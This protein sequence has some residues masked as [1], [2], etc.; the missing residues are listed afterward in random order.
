MFFQ[1]GVDLLQAQGS[2]L[3]GKFVE[4]G[5]LEPPLGTAEELFRKAVGRLECNGKL[6][7]S[8][9]RSSHPGWRSRSGLGT[10]SWKLPVWGGQFLDEQHHFCPRLR[11]FP[12]T[13]NYRCCQHHRVRLFA[14]SKAETALLEPFQGL[15]LEC[16][17][18]PKS[19]AAI[20]QAGREILVAGTAGFDTESKPTFHAG[21][22]NRGPHVVQFALRDRAFIFQLHR[23]ECRALVSDLLQSE[24]VLKVGFGLRND[25]GLIRST[26]GVTLRAILDLDHVF[27]KRGYK[28]QI[29]VRAAVATELNQSFRK[30]KRVTTS[31]WAAP[32]LTPR[33]LLYAANDAFAALRVMEAM[34]L[35]GQSLDI[36]R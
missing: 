15:A 33:Q 2:D 24:S 7:G 21:E 27:R 29:G 18:L 13:P 20:E 3:C 1:R 26:L 23:P 17:H 10:S 32:D 31:N 30:S 35:D 19:A 6:P 11:A 8:G 25:R 16:I 28:G 12:S 36:M 14:P 22:K 9:T 4:P 5:N 34:G